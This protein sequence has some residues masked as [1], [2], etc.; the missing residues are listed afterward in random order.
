RGRTR[1]DRRP[2]RAPKSN[3]RERAGAPAGRRSHPGRGTS[4]P[5][6]DQGGGRPAIADPRYLF[7]RNG[8][9]ESL[10]GRRP[11]PKRLWIAEGVRPDDRLDEIRR[12]ASDAGVPIE[13]VP[14]MLLDDMTTNANHQGVVLDPAEYP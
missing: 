12:L 13:E 4:R 6:G 14:R 3:Q 2:D 7:G 10:R 9:L 1:P 5:R 11:T 8:V